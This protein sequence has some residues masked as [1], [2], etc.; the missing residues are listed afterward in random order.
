MSLRILFSNIHCVCSFWLS[1]YT[2]IPTGIILL[3]GSYDL[4][5]CPYHSHCL[6]SEPSFN[7][8][9]AFGYLLLLFLNLPVAHLRINNSWLTIIYPGFLLE[10]IQTTSVVSL[11]IIAT[12][13]F[14]KNAHTNFCLSY[15]FFPPV[16]FFISAY[17][18]FSCW[19]NVTF[20]R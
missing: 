10:I 6:W 13:F 4:F 19:Q 20:F 14:P 11:W 3:S 1:H 2:C 8:S 18:L 7:L 12:V 5:L 16:S 17:F 9:A 15:R